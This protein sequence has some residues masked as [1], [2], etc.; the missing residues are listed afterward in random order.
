MNP[1]PFGETTGTFCKF[2]SSGLPEAAQ[3]DC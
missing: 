3:A 1:L 2:V